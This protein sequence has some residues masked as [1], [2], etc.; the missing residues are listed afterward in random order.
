MY[1]S[2]LAATSLVPGDVLCVT[3][4]AKLRDSTVTYMI[5]PSTVL[6]A[7]A[8]E[9]FV[10][11]PTSWNCKTSVAFGFLPTAT[12]NPLISDSLSLKPYQ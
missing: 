1:S 7:K 9:T 10:V 12:R 4:P 11:K 2:S 5:S 6:L 3:K 8:R